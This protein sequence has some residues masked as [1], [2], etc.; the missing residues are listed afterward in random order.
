VTADQLLDR[1]L[2]TVAEPNADHLR[3]VAA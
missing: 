1:V 2:A 3:H